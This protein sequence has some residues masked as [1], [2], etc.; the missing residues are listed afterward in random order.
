MSSRRCC[1]KEKRSKQLSPSSR[2]FAIGALLIVR[3]LD[4]GLS[5]REDSWHDRLPTSA[6][7]SFDHPLLFL[8]HA[9]LTNLSVLTFEPN[10]REFL[11]PFPSYNRAVFF[12]PPDLSA[13]VCSHTLPVALVSSVIV[14]SSLLPP[15]SPLPSWR[16]RTRACRHAAT[17]LGCGNGC[18]SASDLDRFRAGRGRP[19]QNPLTV[20]RQVPLVLR[21][22]LRLLQRALQLIDQSIVELVEG[23]WAAGLRRRRARALARALERT[24]RRPRGRPREVPRGQR[25]GPMRRRGEEVR[26]GGGRQ[27]RTLRLGTF[28]DLRSNKFTVRIMAMGKIR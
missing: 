20:S 28:G 21:A 15:F 10:V 8:V 19:A 17:R 6:R 23:I 25:H 11:F 9:G 26:A 3:S 4:R 16:I 14:I 2:I 7:G 13:S 27:R 18:R 5:T 1:S 12:L 24:L 22:V